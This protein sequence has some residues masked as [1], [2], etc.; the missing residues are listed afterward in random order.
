[1]PIYLLHY[2]TTPRL[3]N[4]LSPAEVEAGGAGLAEVGEARGGGET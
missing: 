2:D 1:M 3:R 4:I